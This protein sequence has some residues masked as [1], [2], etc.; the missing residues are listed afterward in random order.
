MNKKIL[1]LLFLL[2]LLVSAT[3]SYAFFIQPAPRDSYQTDLDDDIDTDTF[4]SEIDS[5]FL[6]ENQEIEI[7]EMI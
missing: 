6:D 2:L 3:I 7:G 5:T 1:S 4:L